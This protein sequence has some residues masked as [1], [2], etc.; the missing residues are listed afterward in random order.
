MNLFVKHPELYMVVI[1]AI[2]VPI[3]LGVTLMV[4]K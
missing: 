2:A 3:M 4:M 1:P